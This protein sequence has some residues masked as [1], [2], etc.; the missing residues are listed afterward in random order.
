MEFYFE[1][2]IRCKS[3]NEQIACFSEE[4]NSMVKSGIKPEE[5]LNILGIKNYCSR[6]AFLSPTRV[7]F[8]MENRRLIEGLEP[9]SPNSKARIY[10]ESQ[11]K[12]KEKI[13]F[14]LEENYPENPGETKSIKAE[15]SE[16]ISV[17]SRFYSRSL[18]GRTYLAR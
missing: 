8:N 2:P 14:D 1:Y 3:C 13:N 17:G 18:R 10:E 16:E 5:A 4:F 12:K 7:L 6:L 11:I 9:I 15:L